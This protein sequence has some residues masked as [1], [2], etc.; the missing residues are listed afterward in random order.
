MGEA[1]PGG[2]KERRIGTRGRKAGE[3]K[4]KQQPTE[5]TGD[6]RMLGEGPCYKSVVKGVNALHLSAATFR[7]HRQLLYI[8]WLRRQRQLAATI[9]GVHTGSLVW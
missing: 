3:T 4:L 2:E 8:T 1:R 5:D 9:G 7:G 6:G